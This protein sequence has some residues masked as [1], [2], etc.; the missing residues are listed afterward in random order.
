MDKQTVK[1]TNKRTD[2]LQFITGLRQIT[3]KSTHVLSQKQTRCFLLIKV[4]IPFLSTQ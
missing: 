4:T 3:K 1:K 2:N